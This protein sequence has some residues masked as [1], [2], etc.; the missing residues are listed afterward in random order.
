M[1]PRPTF[2]LLATAVLTCLIA[3]FTARREWNLTPATDSAPG[4]A[5]AAF[6]IQ[7]PVGL[8][9]ERGLPDPFQTEPDPG[10]R[11]RNHPRHHAR[12]RHDNRPNRRAGHLTATARAATPEAGRP[13]RHA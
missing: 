10:R 12:H 4:H 1:T 2:R 7:A 11:D 8:A 9:P 6:G 13:G 3:L 5:P